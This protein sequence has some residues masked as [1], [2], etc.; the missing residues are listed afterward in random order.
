VSL[1]H[2][3][4][5]VQLRR[6]LKQRSFRN[7]YLLP[8]HFPDS[9][10]G[11]MVTKSLKAGEIILSLPKKCLLTTST[12]LESYLGEYIKRW[13]HPISPLLALCSFLIAE[14]HAGI[15]AMWKPYIDILPKTYTCPVYLS[16]E[17]I[18]LLPRPLRK[19]ARE[20]K[21][22]VQELFIS[23]GPFFSSLQRLFTVKVED[24]F[25]YDALRW[26][27]CSINTRT[28]YMKHEPTGFLSGEPDVYA[29]APFLDLLNHSPCVQVAAGFNKENSCYEIQ[30]ATGC[31]KYDQVFICYG[32]HDNQR[33]FLEYGFITSSNPHSVVYVDKDDLQ[34]QFSTTD[35]GQMTKNLRL[36]A[37]HGFLENL[38]FGLDGPSWRLLTAVKVLCLK[39][40]EFPSWKKVLLGA[41]VS[42]AH[43][44]R[45]LNFVKSL[46]CC[47]LHESHKVI[48]KIS[49]LRSTRTES[50][51]LTLVKAL[52][53]EEHQIL[54]KSAEILQNLRPDLT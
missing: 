16:E 43:E 3:A 47:L 27:W 50:E 45:T 6:W 10:R 11:L 14:R 15:G 44:E 33:L 39:P 31:A 26:A 40:E 51:Q 2:E 21:T 8:A 42:Q 25:D 1:S 36:L 5:Y 12:V 28:V 24:V 29:L 37:E 54:L 30:T 49:M 35:N 23:S 46:C 38:T 32:P 19:R 41:S 18:D 4:T 17:V 13:K 7:P 48:Q 53:R 22:V 20:Q 34:P 52:R 9:G